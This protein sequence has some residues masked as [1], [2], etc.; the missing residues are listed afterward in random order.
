MEK[1]DTTSGT[2]QPFASQPEEHQGDPPAEKGL[3]KRV[4]V[5]DYTEERTF[6]PPYH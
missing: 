2:D 5:W 4:L 3:P 6:F 1:A